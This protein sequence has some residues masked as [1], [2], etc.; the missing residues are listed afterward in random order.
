MALVKVI[1]QVGKIQK[2]HVPSAYG[3]G[4]E[5]KRDDIQLEFDWLANPDDTVKDIV[6]EAWTTLASDYGFPTQ[7]AYI[8]AITQSGRYLAASKFKIGDYIKASLEGREG[9]RLTAAEEDKRRTITI[10]TSRADRDATLPPTSTWR[11]PKRTLDQI[12]LAEE[13]EWKRFKESNSFSVDRQVAPAD[14]DRPLE[15]RDQ[16]PESHGSG[17]IH[18]GR[19]DADGFR[20][21]ALPAANGARARTEL[22]ARSPR[23]SEN[24]QSRRGNTLIP[25]PVSPDDEV[26]TSAQRPRQKSLTLFAEDAAHSRRHSS[27]TQ[28]SH[29]SAQRPRPSLQA[30]NQ[31][32]RTAD[33]QHLVDEQLLTESGF[34]EIEECE[35][36]FDDP[37]ELDDDAMNVNGRP[38]SG[39]RGY[40]DHDDDEPPRRPISCRSNAFELMRSSQSGPTQRSSPLNRVPPKQQPAKQ[41]QAKR[42]KSRSSQ[43][44]DR[45][46]SSGVRSVKSTVGYDKR[47][48]NGDWT[49]N[50]IKKLAKGIRESLKTKEI[51][52]KYSIP[53]TESGARNKKDWI[54][55]N[56]PEWLRPD[57]VEPPDFYANV[58]T[59]PLSSGTSTASQKPNKSHPREGATDAATAATNTVVENA[60]VTAGELTQR[61]HATAQ[62][63]PSEN[64]PAITA[65]EPLMEQPAHQAG[66]SVSNAIPLMAKMQQPSQ[67]AEP[68][69][70]RQTPKSQ[71]KRVR[72]AASLTVSRTNQAAVLA[73]LQDP[74]RMSNTTG[75]QS[76]ITDHIGR[77]Q[78]ARPRS[79]QGARSAQGT[80]QAARPS[81]SRSVRDQQVTAG[82]RTRTLRSESDGRRGAR[83]S[84]A[85]LE[86]LS[87]S[88]PGTKSDGTRNK[89]EL[90]QTK[91][92]IPDAERNATESASE[93]VKAG[94]QPGRAMAYGDAKVIPE[95]Q[96]DAV[97]NADTYPCDD[98]IAYEHATDSEAAVQYR[99]DTTLPAPHVPILVSDVD[100]D[101]YPTVANGHRMNDEDREYFATHDMPELERQLAMQLQ[102]ST[103]HQRPA[104]PVPG[105]IRRADWVHA[106]MTNDE[107]R[108]RVHEESRDIV[109][110]ELRYEFNRTKRDYLNVQQ[111]DPP[112]ATKRLA[113]LGK[114]IEGLREVLLQ[115][116]AVPAPRPFTITAITRNSQTKLPSSPRTFESAVERQDESASGTT[117]ELLATH[118]DTVD[119]THRRPLMTDADYA[120]E[121]IDDPVVANSK[122]HI[123]G[124][125]SE[126]D[127]PDAPTHVSLLKDTN[128]PVVAEIDED[129]DDLEAESKLDIPSS[130]VR[131]RLLALANSSPH[132]IPH[133]DDDDESIPDEI[134]C[135][136][137]ERRKPE[138][139]ARCT[140]DQQAQPR[141]QPFLTTEVHAN[142]TQH[143]VTE[144]QAIASQQA[145]PSQPG[146][147][148]QHAQ[149]GHQ[150]NSRPARTRRPSLYDIPNAIPARTQRREREQAEIRRQS[151]LRPQDE[152][153]THAALP[154]AA[155]PANVVAVPQD[156]VP[157]AA[158][159]QL[160][161]QPQRLHNDPHTRH[162]KD[163]TG[164]LRAHDVDYPPALHSR[165]P[166][167]KVVSQARRLQQAARSSSS[168]V[169]PMPP[170]NLDAD[171]PTERDVTH[172]FNRRLVVGNA[173]GTAPTEPSETGTSQAAPISNP[174]PATSA[175][176]ALQARR[177]AR[178]QNASKLPHKTVPQ[179]TR[180]ATSHGQSPH[181]PAL[182]E[183]NSDDTA[184]PQFEQQKAQSE[185]PVCSSELIP[186]V[187][188]TQTKAFEL[189]GA[190]EVELEQSGPS[191]PQTFAMINTGTKT[192]SLAV[193]NADADADIIDNAMDFELDFTE[194]GA[195]VIVAKQDD[196]ATMADTAMH[197]IN[198]TAAL[199]P[200]CQRAATGEP[201]PVDNHKLVETRKRIKRKHKPEVKNR[202][203]VRKSL[204]LRAECLAAPFAQSACVVNLD[205]NANVKAATLRQRP[206]KSKKTEEIGA[207]REDVVLSKK[208]SK[209]SRRKANALARRQSQATSSV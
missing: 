105:A 187:M 142:R 175:T 110:E 28:Q 12:S 74:Q 76:S 91:E 29:T 200:Q 202:E 118:L 2:P 173:N 161:R 112:D 48:L 3:Q 193:A 123:A 117:E 56:R 63:A 23:P 185:P 78:G 44:S 144:P 162:P 113:R 18:T 59:L 41:Q 68:N 53:R 114:E 4:Q 33:L 126:D 97:L 181:I 186:A 39:L 61:V 94:A 131:R 47:A 163:D 180:P 103:P 62:S 88:T 134:P 1:I 15:S 89:R 31:R 204:L 132:V 69:Q 96:E 140:A 197:D 206:E 151:G 115:M 87:L 130:D 146:F 106:G 32:E 90:A 203:S 80:D 190:D 30:Q 20:V 109:S 95:T 147:L 176:E 128:I 92:V 179:R 43:P 169:E 100:F 196:K 170:P 182:L 119:M 209:K 166:R 127:E 172:A 16:R 26:P 184:H 194:T 57:F 111:R 34:D 133:S 14:S 8:S 138:E 71:H 82:G 153:G 79:S 21:P 70:P 155:Q 125:K 25:T 40:D 42:A 145:H 195:P 158:Q 108:K 13:R 139:T 137:K 9:V 160:T 38:H 149:R 10:H 77:D 168:S 66:A 6:E 165:Q 36:E 45:A 205:G 7:F 122:V 22:L 65:E 159:R 207:K 101:D 129:G 17:R 64:E 164:I 188:N 191:A 192:V 37:V 107:I 177:A 54:K 11:G 5:L 116:G 157:R 75:R 148:N 73:S 178:L 152:Q 150:T 27:T 35:K 154:T 50:D 51:L 183:N 81:S 67:Q 83:R 19:L 58:I 143:A 93:Q 135:R 24:S 72:S 86:I 141:P 167:S 49:M 124:E 121:M 85:S 60:V 55:T 156:H 104:R 198:G 98:K 102:D 208:L 99:Q 46:T 52:S 189:D 120:M 199:Q 84:E 174:Q 201:T 171:A 136:M